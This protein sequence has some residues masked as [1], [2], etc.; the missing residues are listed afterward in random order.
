M[1]GNLS[2]LREIGVSNS[3]ERLQDS[4]SLDKSCKILIKPRRWMQRAVCW[5]EQRIMQNNFSFTNEKLCQKRILLFKR[6]KCH[7]QQY[8]SGSF[9]FNRTWVDIK[10]SSTDLK[11]SSSIIIAAAKFA[12]IFIVR[13]MGISFSAKHIELQHVEN[14]TLPLFPMEKRW[15]EYSSQTPIW[16]PLTIHIP[17]EL[18]NMS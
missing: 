14:F 8:E 16:D 6:G 5:Q 13:E 15:A 18:K 1:W 11:V 17:D 4:G 7:P 2:A 9:C 10:L 3:H 12:F